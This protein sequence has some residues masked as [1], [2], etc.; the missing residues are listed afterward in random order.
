LSEG[1][2]RLRFREGFDRQVFLTPGKPVEV[3]VRMS[4]LSHR[5]AAGD[6]LRLLVGSTYFPLLDPNP[7]TGEHIGTGSD[8]RVAQQSVHH[9]NVRPSHVLLPVLQG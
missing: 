8:V 4:H 2:L 7:N 3:T 5:V 1:F 6:R 9:D